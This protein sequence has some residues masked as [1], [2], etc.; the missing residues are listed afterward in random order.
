MEGRRL[1]QSVAGCE[2]LVWARTKEVAEGWLFTRGAKMDAQM[3]ERLLPVQSS[4]AAVAAG[5]YAQLEVLV[6]LRL[7][8]VV[9]GGAV[10]IL[11]TILLTWLLYVEHFGL[12]LPT[13]SGTWVDPPGTKHRATPT[14]PRPKEN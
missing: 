9:K 11:G 6:Q 7:P 10:F 5:G 13:I 14:L 3:A 8:I 2:L 1:L 12:A 4:G